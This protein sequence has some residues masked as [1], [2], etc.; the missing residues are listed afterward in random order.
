MAAI[1]L[2]VQA[3]AIA[4]DL[5]WQTMVFNVLCLSQM[6]HVLAIRSERQSLF[7]IGIFSNKPLIASVILVFMSQA[8][9]TYVPFMQRIFNTESLTIYEFLAVGAISSIIFF[10]VEAEKLFKRRMT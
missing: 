1:A 7:T 9:I 8:V 5:H 2:S 6:A 3:Y 10:A 4:H